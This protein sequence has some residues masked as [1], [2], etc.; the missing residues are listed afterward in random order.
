MLTFLT[1]VGLGL[2]WT[3]IVTD[4]DPESQESASASEQCAGPEEEGQRASVPEASSCGHR[5]RPAPCLI[6]ILLCLS[7]QF[8]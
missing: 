7:F 8:Q 3:V 4:A 6:T 1:A 5:Q 2:L